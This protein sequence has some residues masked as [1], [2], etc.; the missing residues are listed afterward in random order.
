MGMS[1]TACF[2]LAAIAVAAGA[3]VAKAQTWTG[4]V[5]GNW[6]NGANWSSLPIN[7]V[8]ASLTF[9]ATNNPVQNQNLANPFV[10]GAMTFNPGAPTYFVNGNQIQFTDGLGTFTGIIAQN[11]SNP[12]TFNAPIAINSGADI[13]DLN[14]TGSGTVTLNGVV[15]GGIVYNEAP[16]PLYITNPSNTG[17]YLTAGAGT[18]TTIASPT[19]LSGI[20]ANT[21]AVVKL[22][23]TSGNNAASPAYITLGGGTLAV[24]AGSADYYVTA[25]SGGGTLDFTGSADFW[26]HF[27]GATPYID[28]SAVGG[29]YSWI[30]GTG[31][32][33]I[34]NDGTA[35]L[36]VDMNPGTLLTSSI[37]FANG[38]TGQPILVHGGGTLVLTSANNS[39]NLIVDSG[40][41]LQVQDLACLGTGTLTL[42]DSFGV[43]TSPTSHGRLV[44]TGP[45][46]TLAKNITLGSGGGTIAVTPLGTN[47]TISGTIGE[48]PAGPGLNIMGSG[49]G[50]TSVVTLTGPNTYTG[51]TTVFG[52]GILAVNTVTNV[53]TAGPLGAGGNL[54]LG[55]ANNGSGTFVY[56]GASASTDRGITFSISANDPGTIQI[57][58]AG[59]NLTVN[60]VVGGVLNKTGPGALT[61]N[62]STNNVTVANVLA[63]TVAIGSPTALGLQTTVNVSAGATLQNLSGPG[64]NSAFPLSALNLNGGTYADSAAA[65]DF[66]VAK[67]TSQAGGV[68]NLA[69]S[70]NVGL[71]LAAAMP[72]I[73][74]TDNATWTGGGTSHLQSDGGIPTAI[75]ISPGATLNNGIAL[76][77][78]L[79]GLGFQVT[80][81]GTLN[82]TGAATA[83]LTISNGTLQM[84]SAPLLQ[85]SIPLTLDG[86]T[87][88]YTG[89]TDS[90]NRPF[91]VTANGGTVTVSSPTSNLQLAGALTGAG[92]FA[93][94]GPG[95]LAL[96]DASGFTGTVLVDTGVLQLQ[97]PLGGTSAI[98]VNAAGT[99]QFAASQVT[100]RT[101][102]LNF[103]TLSATPGTTVTLSGAAVNG[104]FLRGP[105]AFV[106]TGGTVLAGV[107]SQPDAVLGQTGPGTFV[108][109]T[110]GGALSVAA[111][112]APPVP[113]NGFTNQGSGS[114]AL[115]AGSQV[116]LSS[117]Q[118]YGTLTLAAGPS[119]ATPTLLTNTGTTPLYF[120]GGSRTFVSDVAH[121]G[122]PA[123]VDL[124]GQDAVVAGGLFVNNGAVF[125]SLASPAGHH[126][127]VADYGATIKGAG[128]FQFAPITQNGGKFSPGN[129]PGQASFGQ[130]RFGP[131]GV[132]DYVF[133][134]NDATGTAGPPPD[135]Q[136]H[137]SG[138]DLAKAVQMTV[139]SAA[140]PGDFAWAADSAHPLTLAIDTLVNPSIVGTDVAG[141][142]VHFD[143]TQPYSWT[144]V[145]WTGA[146]SGPT[147]AAA[148]DAATA[149]DTSG[150]VNPFSGSFGWSFG[151][152]GHSLDL[153]YT[154]VP[155]PGTLALTG[156]AA[157]GWV[158]FWRRRW[159]RASVR[160]ARD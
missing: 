20:Q 147:A 123:Y 49:A 31:F 69:G 45:T 145:E 5:N 25:I 144:A 91:I 38:T 44:Y 125:D 127:L 29:S 146:Y 128:L 63:G 33:R 54:V 87:F 53:G 28:L 150:V 143:P 40:S 68:I 134:I 130:F 73:T 46:A 140:T 22:G 61:L 124:H 154:P 56:Q 80:G 52:G 100:G 158:A 43:I 148:L 96:T 64:D 7:N 113:F 156:L 19:A 131:G 107:T 21:G 114:I 151:P 60:G 97:G 17:A 99:A 47:L 138:W 83:P 55:L 81:G 110:N 141:P 120:N 39:A 111:G 137:V 23:F 86:G 13:L 152:D 26:L 78:G 71:H 72:S 112:L 4:A 160:S 136:G 117:F 92:L 126:N 94:E 135:G 139:G 37:S 98:A 90:L 30:G 65:N 41:K 95:T 82:Q 101:F 11:S 104:G 88:K 32:S 2:M 10:L 85:T 16:A 12:V 122:G 93:K 77:I 142:M 67:I 36:N 75:N 106:V 51:P 66:Y 9:G 105:G 24:P 50:S 118:S 109:F 155:E 62:N 3:T 115:G 157:V 76:A 121:I 119:T 132:S 35:P 108:N 103:G 129:S 18:T 79:S 34:Q 116:N 42:Q 27:T 149:F 159:A 8:N 74:V 48:S 153:T 84:A 70:T 15:S 89:P 57:A 6:N 1:R 133:Q 14:G 59:T 102:N 58:T